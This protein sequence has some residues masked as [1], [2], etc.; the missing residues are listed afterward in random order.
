MKRKTRLFTAIGA[1]C[2]A[3]GLMAFGVYAATTISYSVNGTVNYEMTDVLVNVVTTLKYVQDDA[4]TTDVKENRIGYDATTAKSAVYDGTDLS[5][6]TTKL[7]GDTSIRT[8]DES[9]VANDVESGNASLNISFNDSTAW[10]IQIEITNVQKDNGVDIA[11]GDFGIAEGA[12][13]GLIAADSNA[14]SV[15]ADSS[16]TL[17]YYLYLIDATTSITNQTF[18]IGL[19][20]TQS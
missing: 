13:Y 20:L 2:L 4:E 14:T 7:T 6:L 19:T 12:N 18:T 5:K 8:Y 3:I 9:N 10:Q 17:T 11:I 15:G 1:L 16:T